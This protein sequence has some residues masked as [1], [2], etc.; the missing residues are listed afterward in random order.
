[1]SNFTNISFL[2]E[3]CQHYKIDTEA[4]EYIPAV[5]VYGFDVEPDTLVEET[6]PPSIACDSLGCVTVIKVPISQHTAVVKN[7]ESLLSSVR[8][9]TSVETHGFEPTGEGRWRAAVATDKDSTWVFIVDGAMCYNN[10]AVLLKNTPFELNAD[11][12]DALCL[13]IQKDGMCILSGDENS[14]ST[15]SYWLC[16][17]APT[18][19]NQLAARGWI[20]WQAE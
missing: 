4:D 17:N 19:Y 1:M 9:G 18:V 2:I 16:E 13:N 7:L 8:A 5:V 10:H 14:D 12:N 6:N 3:L 11:E 20:T 15:F